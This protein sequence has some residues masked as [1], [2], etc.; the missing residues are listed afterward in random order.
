MH[1]KLVPNPCKLVKSSE[2]FV[3][4]LAQP[5]CTCFTPLASSSTY[6]VGTSDGLVH[7]CLASTTTL[8][9]HYQA[10]FAGHGSAV[11][12]VSCCP[13]NPLFFVTSDSSL[14]NS[15][16][17]W[18]DSSSDFGPLFFISNNRNCPVVGVCWCAFN[19]KL[20]AIAFEEGVVEVWDVTA[21]HLHDA[22]VPLATLHLHKYLSSRVGG[23]EPSRI[24]SLYW[25]DSCPLMYVGTSAGDVV[26][27]EV[28]G[29]MK[30]S[31]DDIK[32]LLKKKNTVL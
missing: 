29:G 24:T 19:P 21:V 4:R 10:T 2:P 22:D 31:V 9:E 3:S 7:R 14:S 17:V 8:V 16:A 12:S 26:V 25:A 6:L 11:Q 5:L 13:G 28:K 27:M 30:G 20:V 15:V 18:N 23:C 1:F 32:C